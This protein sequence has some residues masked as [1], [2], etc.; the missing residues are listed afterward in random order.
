M[1]NSSKDIFNRQNLPENVALQKT[2]HYCYKK[3]KW[4]ALLLVCILILPPIAANVIILCT[5]NAI[6][7]KIFIVLSVVE[8][9]IGEIIKHFLSKAKFEGAS[10]QQYFDEIVFGLKK[11]SRKYLVPK[12]LKG[13]ER[14][15]LIVKY[16]N[17]PDVPFQNWYSDYSAL[18]YEQAIY[19]C[20]KENLRWDS[21]IRKKYFVLLILQFALLIIGIIVNAILQKVSVITL[22]AVL[23]TIAPI[24]SYFYSAFHKLYK[25]MSKQKQLSAAIAEID[26]KQE[27]MNPIT[28][29]IEELQLEI[30]TYRKSLYLIP[31]WFYKLSRPKMQQAEDNLA[32]DICKEH[33]QI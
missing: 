2:A 27:N 33:H 21:T 26:A 7:D 25:D 15:R 6:A 9:F 30:F 3:G 4:L 22:I 31:D 14:R 1:D 17:K 20:Q 12:K 10:L 19:N 23:S 32:E 5:N 29:E 28:D 16:K 11:S 24:F 13:D 18:P 8:F